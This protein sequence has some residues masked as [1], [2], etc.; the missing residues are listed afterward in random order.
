MTPSK[1]KIGLALF[2]IYLVVYGGF[3]LLN[4]FAPNTMQAKPALGLNLAVLYGFGLILLAFALAIIYGFV[5]RSAADEGA[6]TAPR[7]R[8]P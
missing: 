1:Q 2:A 6:A 8:Q 4:A 3:V 5:S 7:E